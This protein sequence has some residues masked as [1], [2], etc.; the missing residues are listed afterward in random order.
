MCI[1]LENYLKNKIF[2]FL[3]TSELLTIF[4]KHIYLNVFT[5]IIKNNKNYAEEEKNKQKNNFEYLCGICHF[6]Y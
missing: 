3:F 2:K 4:L 6:Y 5:Y 1:I